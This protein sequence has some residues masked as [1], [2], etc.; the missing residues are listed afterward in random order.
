MSTSPIQLVI[1]GIW[2]FK[3]EST[4][5]FLTNW[6]HFFYSTIFYMAFLLLL[7]ILQ[8][9]VSGNAEWTKPSRDLL[10]FAV[11][12]VLWVGIHPAGAVA[13]AAVEW[14]CPP[15]SLIATTQVPVVP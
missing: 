12:P 2:F 7:W 15:V 8:A 6:T 9:L 14:S 10:R 3:F 11:C 13:M 1:E 4:Y 5:G